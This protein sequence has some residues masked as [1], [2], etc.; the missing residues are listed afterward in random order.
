M[1]EDS[2]RLAGGGRIRGWRRIR[3]GGRIRGGSRVAGGFADGGG[4]AEGGGFAGGGGFADGDMRTGCLGAANGADF[5]RSSERC[6]FS[7]LLPGS[8]LAMVL[9]LDPHG[10]S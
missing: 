3:G 6:D 1:G 5:A 9:F 4:F 7:V 8:I 2:R 10:K